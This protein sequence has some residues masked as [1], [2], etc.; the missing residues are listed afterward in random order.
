LSSRVSSK[1]LFVEDD[2]L[3]GTTPIGF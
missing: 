2:V 3:T 1:R